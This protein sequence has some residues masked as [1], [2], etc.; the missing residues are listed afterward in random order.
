VNGPYTQD[1]ETI[2]TG[3][4]RNPGMNIGGAGVGMHLGKTKGPRR[5]TKEDTIVATRTGAKICKDMV[6][7]MEVTGIRITI[8][9]ERGGTRPLLGRTLHPARELGS[10]KTDRRESEIR[11]CCGRNGV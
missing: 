7:T 8:E 1:N 9:T 10:R 2:I 5:D 4:V 3:S 6:M 11:R